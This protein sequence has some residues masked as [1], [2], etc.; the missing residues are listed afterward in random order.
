MTINN[1]HSKTHVKNTYSSDSSKR[2][3]SAE[4]LSFQVLTKPEFSIGE[5]TKNLRSLYD[6]ISSELGQHSQK[7]IELIEQLI[8]SLYQFKV[9]N[10][11]HW[12][13]LAETSRTHPLF[14]QCMEDPLTRRAY[15]KPRGYAGDA[16]LMDYFYYGKQEGDDISPL[17]NDIMT[18]MRANPAGSAVRSRARVIGRTIDRLYKAKNRKLRILSIACGHSREPSTSEAFMSGN[19]E[20][21]AL[22]Q[23]RRSLD[24]I[25]RDYHNQHV[26]TV[27]NSVKELVQDRGIDELG[28]FD[29]VYASGLFD[30]LKDRVATKLTDIMFDLLKPG[31]KVFITNYM[32]NTVFSG[33]MEAIM[34]WKLIYRDLFDIEVLGK[35]I[36]TEN[37]RDKMVFMED[38]RRVAFLEINKLEHTAKTFY[39]NDLRMDSLKTETEKVSL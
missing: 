26:T 8:V 34:D 3:L 37:I 9:T 23:D 12:L 28:E 31:G 36:E 20:L 13:E 11:V 10:P 35:N 17:G 25:E 32:P 39:F 27:Q 1:S 5:Q 38:N 21:V 15:E 14:K 30:Y 18:C 2:T 33:Y 4:S 19:V 22:D 7:N 24:L 6:Q 29:L 16:C